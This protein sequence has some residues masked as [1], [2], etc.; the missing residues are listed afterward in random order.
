MRSILVLLCSWLWASVTAV[1]YQGIS[2]ASPPRSSV[3]WSPWGIT[4]SLI[5]IPGF[6]VQESEWTVSCWIYITVLEDTATVFGLSDPQMELAWAGT[7]LKM[8]GVGPTAQEVETTGRPIS[9]WFH[10]ILGSH[11]SVSFG[12]VT[13]KGGAQYTLTVNQAVILTSQARVFATFT[14]ASFT[15]FSI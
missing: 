15:V 3:Y 10:A 12:V 2:P 13:I 14:R 5:G 8:T 7:K 9:K 4:W 11:G 6:E 1:R